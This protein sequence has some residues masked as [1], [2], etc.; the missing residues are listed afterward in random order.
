MWVEYLA[1]GSLES[2]QL[3]C[4]TEHQVM[5]YS[6]GLLTPESFFKWLHVFHC[7]WLH[8]GQNVKVGGGSL[9]PSP[10]L[11]FSCWSTGVRTKSLGGAI[12]PLVPQLADVSAS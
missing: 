6:G 5:P 3:D 4:P 8:S 2:G 7:R 11:I 1:G 9:T 12:S 10:G